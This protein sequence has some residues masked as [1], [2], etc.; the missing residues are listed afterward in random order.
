MAQAIFPPDL[1][2]NVTE[3]EI[4]LQRPE[5]K[6]MMNMDKAMADI[7]S[8]R[9]LQPSERLRE[10]IK[11]F[12]RFR[13]LR[14][15]V[16][17]NGTTQVADTDSRSATVER[18]LETETASSDA[19]RQLPSTP[20]NN[21]EE[22]MYPNITAIKGAS[23]EQLATLDKEPQIHL[24]KEFL[25]ALEDS[26]EI[27]HAPSGQFFMPYL[28]DVPSTS[29]SMS[30]KNITTAVKAILNF[31]LEG[32]TLNKSTVDIFRDLK[33][34]LKGNPHVYAAIETKIPKSRKSRNTFSPVIPRNLKYISLRTPHRSNKK[35]GAGVHAPRIF[36][37][38]DTT[39]RTTSRKEDY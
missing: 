21:N 31:L 16:L 6:K 12:A 15:D 32:G 10:Y 19:E 9:D 28:S 18:G 11:I 25:K 17:I 20:L 23:N 24:A 13:S 8:R 1:I 34:L 4:L 30:V 38:W 39:F 3:G 36:N 26:E 14:D 2:S 29:S 35:Q 5:M 22:F 27:D 37:V 7:L 33:P